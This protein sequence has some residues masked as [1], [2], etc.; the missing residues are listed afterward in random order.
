[1]TGR[2]GLPWV[3]AALRRAGRRGLFGRGADVARPALLATQWYPEGLLIDLQWRAVVDL[4]A[5]A[6]ESSPFYRQRLGPVNGASALTRDVFTHVPRLTRQDV[7]S[8][9]EAIRVGTAAGSAMSRRSGGS[10]GRSVS[11]PI[12]SATYSWYL[13]GTW[14]GLRHWGSDLTD[15]G[16][17]LLGPARGGVWGLAAKGK[18]WAMN[19]LRLAVD[20]QFERCA[21]DVLARLAAFSPTF[22]YAFPSAMDHLACLAKALGWRPRAQVKVIVLT[23]EPVYAFQ[24]RRISEAFQCP[25][26]EEYGSGEL[27]SMAFECPDGSLHVTTENVFLETVTAGPPD[28]PGGLVLATQLH[29]RL[30]PLIRY[31]TGDV[32]VLEGAGCRCG[33]GLPTIRVLGRHSVGPTNGAGAA[34]TWLQVN[35]LLGMLPEPLQ[36]HVQV[37]HAAPRS[38]VLRVE[39]G[40]AGREAL[41]DTAAVGAVA[42][43]DGWRLETVEAERL[44]RLPSGKLPF[45]LDGRT[46]P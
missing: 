24:R 11:I 40:S 34:P 22:I 31:E 20:S 27:G 32:G 21:P 43:D 33:R 3:A 12:D 42:F 14:R 16:A 9:R 4:V 2:R 45:L 7:T 39:R 5:Y 41:A 44:L 17:V 28:A 38:L 18:D 10:S 23:G 13:A 37:F 36:G 8:C 35:Q 29:N 26:A 15:R 25:V 19:W 1:M 46:T 30:F 6:R